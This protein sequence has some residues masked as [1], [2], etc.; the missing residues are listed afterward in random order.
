MGKLSSPHEDYLERIY[1]LLLEKGYAR[2]IDIS[3]RLGVKPASVTM[4]LKKLEV[5]GYIDR[6]KYRGFTLT[7]KGKEVGRNIRNRH[8]ILSEFF[9]LLNV[10]QHVRDHDIDGLEHY[11]S[12]ETLLGLENLVDRLKSDSTENRTPIAGM[13]ALRPSR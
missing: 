5:A 3:E 11:L 12:R 9:E 2:V 10:P 1:E 13:K 4:M 7:Q 6:E 8:K